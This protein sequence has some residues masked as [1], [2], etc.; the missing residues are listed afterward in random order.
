MLLFEG[1]IIVKGPIAQSFNFKLSMS[2]LCGIDYSVAYVSHIT[3]V[4]LNLH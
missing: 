4:L 3:A 1:N 2:F